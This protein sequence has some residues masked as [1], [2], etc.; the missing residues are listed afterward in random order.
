MVG[1]SSCITLCSQATYHAS[2]AS[3]T[4]PGRFAHHKREERLKEA[5]TRLVR[6]LV[7]MQAR[8]PPSHLQ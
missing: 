2:I 5:A 7:E 1:C 3:T 4:Q 8:I 6:T